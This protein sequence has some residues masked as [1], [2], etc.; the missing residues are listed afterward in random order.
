MEEVCWNIEPTKAAGLIDEEWE[1]WKEVKQK[2]E[3]H[4]H[5]RANRL[6]SLGI[7][8]ENQWG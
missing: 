1:V 6:T 4:F 3:S 2:R 7:R 5:D 8:S